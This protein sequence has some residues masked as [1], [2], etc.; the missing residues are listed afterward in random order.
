METLVALALAAS[1][2]G[3]QVDSKPQF[4]DFDAMLQRRVVRVMVPYSRTLYFNDRGAQRGLTADTLRDFEVFLNRKYP[5]KAQPIVVL[6]M[7]VT[8]ERMISG[9]VQGHADLAAGNLTITP[10]RDAKVDFSKPIAQGP[11]EIVVAGPRSPKLGTLD[12]LGGHDVHVRASSSYYFSLV[13]L[14]KRLVAEGKPAVRIALVPDALEDEDLMDMVAAGLIRL[15]VVDGWKADI[16]S[17]MQKRL[18]PRKDLA[19]TAEQSVGWALR[20]GSPKLAALVDEFI[21]RY[22]GSRAQRYRS[23]PAYVVQLGHATADT[24]WKRF[25]SSIALFRKYAPRYG[26][27]PL[28]AAALGYQESRLD[29]AARSSVGA[30]GVMQLMPDTARTLDVGDVTEIEPNIHGGIKYLRILRQRAISGGSPDEQNLTLFALAAYNCGPGRV[31]AL[32]SE[33]QQTG[34]DPDV[35]FDNVE[36]VAARRVGQ[37]TVTFVRNIYKYYVGYKLQLETLEARRAAAAKYAPPKKA[38][39]GKAK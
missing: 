32:R 1:A 20:A 23:Y 22:P 36:R 13:A 16:W 31:A 19:L 14:N 10:E 17:R 18:K 29:Q 35:W 25:Q 39:A 27:D 37:E 11:G 34:L 4:G 26:L 24:D 38:A 6:A 2:T 33:A 3:L 21:D 28:M 30:I 8:R 7:P 9:L 5:H 15:T 12:D